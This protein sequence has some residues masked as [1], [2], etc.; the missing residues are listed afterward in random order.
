[1]SFGMKNSR[2]A[3][4]PGM[5]KILAGLDNVNC[6][7]DVLILF[8]DDWKM[9]LQAL[10]KLFQCLQQVSLTVRPRKSVIGFE[11]AEFLKRYIGYD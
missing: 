6:F 9:H 3:L 7:V 11:S 1:M 2:A 8:K 10:E 5:R 4:A